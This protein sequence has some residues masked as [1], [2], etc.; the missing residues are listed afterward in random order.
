MLFLM[1]TRTQLTFFAARAL[2]AHAQLV[3][4]DIQVL[5]CKAFQ[6]AG[7]QLALVYG[8]ISP[9][10][11]DLCTYLCWTSWNSTQ[12]VSQPVKVLL[13]GSITN[14]FQ[15]TEIFLDCFCVFGILHYEALF[16]HGSGHKQGKVCSCLQSIL[17]NY[18]LPG[19]KKNIMAFIFLFSDTSVVFISNFPSWNYIN[20]II[21]SNRDILFMVCYNN[22]L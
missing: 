8:F 15:Y 11:Q 3:Y 6:P 5:F 17:N 13:N 14:W 21:V 12:H 22:C 18:F 7:L 4:Q 19:E 2:L 9:Q 10:A 20:Y 16:W 1:Q